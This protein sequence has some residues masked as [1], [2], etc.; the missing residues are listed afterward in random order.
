MDYRPTG[1]MY[2]YFNI[3]NT[4]AAALDLINMRQSF[5][6][7]IYL[8]YLHNSQELLSQDFVIFFRGRRCPDSTAITRRRGREKKQFTK[9]SKWFKVPMPKYLK[10]WHHQTPCCGSESGLEA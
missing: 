8:I 10:P 1:Y 4:V 9:L 6:I 5:I 7:W 3:N 2:D